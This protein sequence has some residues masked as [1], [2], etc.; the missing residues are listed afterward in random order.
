MKTA[1]GRVRVRR[2]EDA[3]NRYGSIER[4]IDEL[5]AGA[6]VYDMEKAKT[7]EQEFAELEAEADVAEDL[8]R[9]K[10]RVAAAG[11]G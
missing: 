2:V 1:K 8:A 5:E 7:L 11:R 10:A 3:L 4:R 6:E 9:L